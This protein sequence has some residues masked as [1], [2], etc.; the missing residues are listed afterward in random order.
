MVMTV[1]FLLVWISRAPRGAL[2][3]GQA[4]WQDGASGWDE[5]RRKMADCLLEVTGDEFFQTLSTR[6][7]PL[8][9]KPLPKLTR[10]K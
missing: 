6:L 3:P 4:G 2:Q 1:V 8:S 9:H 7:T 5:S 10:I